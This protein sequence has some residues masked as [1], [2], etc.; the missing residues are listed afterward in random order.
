MAY[1]IALDLGTS[2][3]RSH[4]VDLDKGDNGQTPASGCEHNGSYALLDDFR[5]GD[6]A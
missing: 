6:H 1:G 3:F 4:L 5:K 2:G